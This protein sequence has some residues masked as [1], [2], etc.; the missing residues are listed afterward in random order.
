MSQSTADQLNTENI[1]NMEWKIMELRQ[2]F[3]NAIQ[4]QGVI[5]KYR[6]ETHDLFGQDNNAS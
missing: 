6:A 1:P 3:F 5:L 4:L 2:G